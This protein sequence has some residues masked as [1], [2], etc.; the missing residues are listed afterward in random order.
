MSLSRKIATFSGA[1]L[2]IFVLACRYSR[3]VAD[4]Y[5]VHLYPGISAVLSSVSSLVPFSLQETAGV[6]SV[7]LAI[8]YLVRAA[9]H[10]IRWRRFFGNIA[11]MVL[12]LFVWCY[13][14]WACNYYRSSIYERAGK[15]PARFDKEVF[16][17][18]LDD[19][20]A[21]LNGAWC[22][23]ACDTSALELETHDW[24]AAVDPKFGLAA[25]CEWQHPKTSEFSR[26]WTGAGVTGFIGPMFAEHHIMKGIPA[27]E[28]PFTYA[29]EYS[30]VLGVS[31]EA[32]ANWW[33]YEACSNSSDPAARYSA[34]AFIYGY[35]RS[36]AAR[37][38]EQDE[39]KEWLASVR[40]E[41]K[42]DMAEISKWW[43]AARIEWFDKVQ[44]WSYNLFL[45]GN[46]ISSGTK[47]YSEIIALIIALDGYQ[48]Q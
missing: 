41:V 18:F 48:D 12:W 31:N 25:P 33:A 7:A 17:S 11:L 5:A 28:Y 23:A 1:A 35:V 37:L 6:A 38:L 26:I 24:Y 22:D 36:N 10:R 20:T 2:A 39:Y 13:V 9:T 8:W 46:R 43:Q 16:A 47:N 29:H 27:L 45:K 30:H 14:G 32:E 15:S 42:E 3:E 4:F 19:Y 40:P 21:K 44:T 34:Y